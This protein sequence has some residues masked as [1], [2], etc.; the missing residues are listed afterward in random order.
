MT[1]DKDP[2]EC[3]NMDPKQGHQNFEEDG[4]QTNTCRSLHATCRAG[5]STSIAVY[6]PRITPIK[7]LTM[8][9]KDFRLH[10]QVL[11]S[12]LLC[13]TDGGDCF[14]LLQQDQLDI[15]TMTNLWGKDE[16]TVIL[17]CTIFLLLGLQAER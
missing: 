15:I 3:D 9:K 11:S 4:N 16:K 17:S 12:F 14:T 6:Q 5:P 1:D 2:N 7:D 13:R 10:V 8:T